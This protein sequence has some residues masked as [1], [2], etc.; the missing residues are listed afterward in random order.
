MTAYELFGRLPAGQAGEIFSW[1]H[2]RDRAAYRACIGLLANRRK[3]RPVFVER[4]PRDERHTWMKDA[5]SRPANGDMAGEVLQ[6]WILGA[7]TK[8]VLDFLDELKVEHD[9]KGLIEDLPAEPPAES[10]TLAVENLFRLHPPG[11]VM[12]YLNLFAGMDDSD[13]PHLKTLV[14]SDPRLCPDPQTTS[15]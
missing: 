13:W 4:K 9:G 6:G 12:V 3:L 11:A 10:V 15:P 8:M 7:H 2:E 5:L 14:S 1:F